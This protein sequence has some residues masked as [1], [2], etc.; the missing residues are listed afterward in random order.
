MELIIELC[1]KLHSKRLGNGI[2]T[3]AWHVNH[4]HGMRVSAASISR[5][6]CAVGAYRAIPARPVRP[7][8]RV[9]ITA[10]REPIGVAGQV[11]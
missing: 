6:L 4:H 8:K 9:G 1:E 3:I 2:Q 5:Q 10:S 7:L 11:S